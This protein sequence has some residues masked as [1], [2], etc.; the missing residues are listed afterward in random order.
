MKRQMSDCYLCMKTYC[1]AR[2]ISTCVFETTASTMHAVAT[3]G[4]KDSFGAKFSAKS[5]AGI[6]EN[7]ALF[8]V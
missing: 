2:S 5:E 6:L 4:G 7:N 8:C 1:V 3:S